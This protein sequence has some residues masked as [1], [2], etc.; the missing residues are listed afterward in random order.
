M[1][2]KGDEE[3]YLCEQCDPRPIDREV[4]FTNQDMEEESDGLSYYMTLMRDDM[5]IRVW[6]CVYLLK[7]VHAR[8]YSYKK[9]GSLRRDKMDIFRVERLWK[10]DK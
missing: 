7:E 1:L 2:V 4:K 8:R 10:D 9:T 6:S 5:Q 3:N